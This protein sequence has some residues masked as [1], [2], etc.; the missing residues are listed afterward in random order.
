VLIKKAIKLEKGSPK[1]HVRQGRQAHPRAGEEIA[2]MKMPDLTA[3]RPGRRGPN[4]RRLRP[5]D[6]HHGGRSLTM[7]KLT[8]T[9]KALVGKVDRNK[10][11][12]LG[13]AL[14]LVKRLRHRQVRRV[15]RRGRAARRRCQE[16]PTRWCAARS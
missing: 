14:E 2:K 11:Y 9:Q 7:A 4:H 3:S 10:V 5:L 16:E 6:G 12:P 15:D 13:D 8:K 1:P